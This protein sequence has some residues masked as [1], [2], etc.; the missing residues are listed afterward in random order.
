MTIPLTSCSAGSPTDQLQGV[1]LEEPQPKPSFVLT[2]TSGEKYDFV[3]RTEGKLT[4]LYF[5]Y[6][7][8]PDICP[9][10]MAQIART[11]E[12]H[13]EIE[14]QSEVVFVSVDPERDTPSVLRAFLDNF[15]PNFVGLTGTTAELEVAEKA[16][17]VP[18]A[19]VVGGG[20]DYSVNHAAWVV[21]YAPDGLS[22]S[23][24]PFGVKQSQWNNDLQIL[25][26]IEGS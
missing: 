12:E 20:E 7:N 25:A 26:A 10:H 15:G 9:V 4:L 21:V 5:G 6:T 19:E 14:D 3:T 17:G 22:Y 8:C 24:Y 2:E 1:L 13:P 23:F 11:F 16:A 18:M